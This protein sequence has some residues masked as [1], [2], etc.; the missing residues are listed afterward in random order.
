MKNIT[1]KNKN[2]DPNF[3]GSFLIEPLS[4]CDDIIDHFEAN[5]VRQ[6]RGQVGGGLHDGHKNS[7][8]MT[9]LPKEINMPGNEIFLSYFNELL[10]CYTH[11]VSQWPFLEKFDNKI[12]IGKFNIQRY[13][14]GQH[15]QAIHTERA[16]LG[17]LHRIF[18]WMTYLNDVDV[19]EGGSTHFTHYDMEVQ[20]KKG[21]TLIWPAEWTH[22]H[23]GNKMH[24]GTKYIMT[25]WMH[26]SE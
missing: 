14:T 17:T 7:T 1:L 18:A 9:L 6:T 21:L 22:A 19:E 20:P 11:Y 15:F 25:G 23:R 10:S 8:D 5:K 26:F 3:I 13:R 4:L 16:S 2:L 12:D 24:S